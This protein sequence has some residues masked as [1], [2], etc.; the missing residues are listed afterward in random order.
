MPDE[1]SG[2][3]GSNGLKD[4]REPQDDEPRVGIVSEL[5]KSRD[6][7]MVVL[8]RDVLALRLTHS[9]RLVD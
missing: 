4:R 7:G 3:V 6:D 8:I 5:E 2:T 9:L 1:R